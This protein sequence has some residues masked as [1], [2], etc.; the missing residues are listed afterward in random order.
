VT[1]TEKKD[2]LRLE[3]NP[4]FEKSYQDVMDLLIEA[5]NYVE[6]QEKR[7]IQRLPTDMRLLVNQETM[8]IT[9]RLTQVMAW[10][11][12]QKA[13]FAGEIDMAEVFSEKFE[14]GGEVI[15]LNN[16]WASDERLPPAV[17]DLLERSLN[18]Y[19]RVQRLDDMMRDEF[20][21]A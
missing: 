17:R 20:A 21:Y 16:E 12:C 18:L 13:Y 14:I 6:Y 8:R 1:D 4:F 19:R 10:M 11:L 5:R 9:C 7:D 3:E 2:V 15:C